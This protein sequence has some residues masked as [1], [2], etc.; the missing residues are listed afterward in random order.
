MYDKFYFEL[1]YF[2]IYIV[3][4]VHYSITRKNIK[5]NLRTST[6]IDLILK[7]RRAFGGS[8]WQY[9]SVFWYTCNLKGLWR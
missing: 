4:F 7:L 1:L 5:I 9:K 2:V 3:L 8:E 6:D